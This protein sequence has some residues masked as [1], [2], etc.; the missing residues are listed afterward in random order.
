MSGNRQWSARL[1]HCN[2]YT[3]ISAFCILET[4]YPM[5]YVLMESRSTAVED[6]RRPTDRVSNYQVILKLR[7]MIY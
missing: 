1:I 3:S 7:C 2:N 6:L 5:L 4:L